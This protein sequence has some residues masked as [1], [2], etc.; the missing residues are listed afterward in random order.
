MWESV[1][2]LPIFAINMEICR[3]HIYMASNKQYNKLLN[4]GWLLLLF[5]MAATNV[6]AQR[7]T[8]VFGVIKDDQGAPIELASVRAVGQNALTFTNLKG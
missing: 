3:Y 7:R 1:N 5:A 2:Q 4:S 6:Y 8:R